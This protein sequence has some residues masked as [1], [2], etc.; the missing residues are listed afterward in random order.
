[1][2]WWGLTFLRIGSYFSAGDTVSIFSI[3]KYRLFHM[4]LLNS[5]LDYL[6]IYLFIIIIASN[7]KFNLLLLVQLAEWGAEY[8]DRT[9]AEG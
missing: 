7:Y 3:Y 1:M 5:D 2:G 8:T 4:R 9:S 6:F